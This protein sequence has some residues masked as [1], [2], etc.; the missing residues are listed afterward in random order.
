[1]SIPHFHSVTR[2]TSN[3]SPVYRS[4][5]TLSSALPSITTPSYQQGNP[6]H[7]MDEY[8]TKLKE[9]PNK[10]EKCPNLAVTSLELYPISNMYCILELASSFSLSEYF[11]EIIK[12]LSKF[13]SFLFYKIYSF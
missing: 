11:S 10:L 9:S 2:T 13:F 1:M 12:F 4:L 7:E 3:D 5:S 8:K 6:L